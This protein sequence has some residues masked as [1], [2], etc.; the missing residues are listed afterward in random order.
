MNRSLAVFFVVALAA[1]CSSTHSDAAPTTTAAPTTAAPT[2]A[3]PPPT[4][5]PADQAFRTKVP[6]VVSVG[7]EIVE[8]PWYVGN[9]PVS[10]TQGFEYDLAKVIAARLQIGRASWRG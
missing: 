7:V 9:G 2:T 5:L 1:G 3:A 6:G 8:P 10:I 4:T